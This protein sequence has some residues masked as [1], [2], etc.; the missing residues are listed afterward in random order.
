MA[1]FRLA[2][3]KFTPIKVALLRF[4]FSKL[5]PSRLT[6]LISRELRSQ[7]GHC[8]VFNIAVIAWVRF[9]GVFYSK[10]FENFIAPHT[11]EYRYNCSRL[12]GLSAWIDDEY[13]RQ[14]RAKLDNSISFRVFLGISPL[15]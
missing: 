9:I 14:T 8:L 4:A 3:A 15:N 13:R 11:T 7:L 10:P 2:P 6:F 5:A 1:C 12:P